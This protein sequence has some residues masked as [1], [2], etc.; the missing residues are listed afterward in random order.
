M[1]ARSLGAVMGLVAM[2]SAC[3][4]GGGGGSGTAPSPAPGGTPPTTTP[5]PTPTPTAANGCSLRERQDWA[6]AQLREW[7]LFPETLP[8]NLDPTPYASVDAFID[9]MTSGARA[10]RKDRY[11][12]YLTSIAEENAFYSSGAS[13]AFGFR[14][15]LT[16]DLHRLFVTEAFEQSPAFIAGLDRGTEILAIGT[17][18]SNLRTIRTI[19]DAEGVA[20]LAS[21]LGPETAGNSRLLRVSDRLGTREV[22]VAVADFDMTPV[23]NRY[24]AK[25]LESAGRRVGYVNLRTF[26]S[27]ADPALRAAFDQ[28]RAQGITELIVDLRYN[29]GGLLSTA[30]LLGDLLGGNRATAEVFSHT[31]F[32]REKASENRTR[33]F[34]PQPQSIGPTRIAFIGT[35]GTASASEVVIN[36][37]TPYLHERA[38]LIGTNTYGKPVGQIGL[39]RPACDDRLRI[40]AL[41]TQN[42][43]GRGDYYDGLAGVVEASCQAIDDIGYPLGDPRE[44]SI[45]QALDFLGGRGCTRIGAAGT[46]VG[47]TSRN[48]GPGPV[49]S[50][51]L[52]RPERPSTPQREVPG[53]F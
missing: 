29:G 28:F 50:R 49:D 30:E 53:L 35:P 10:L 39:D 3:G 7:Y 41:A 37:M 31:V 40:V 17:N 44:A 22:T 32:R 43:A 48:G 46:A 20:G 23:S 26:I 51:E 8:A 19:T 4:G 34:A 6:A 42:S 21:A 2:L 38:A 27:T 12:T 45:R 11:F 15:A 52:I 13:A 24:G 1:K 9:A 16:S 33:T 5:T 18:A 25:I 47:S 36:A 14:L